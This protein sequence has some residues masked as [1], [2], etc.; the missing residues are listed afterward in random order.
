MG[1][2]RNLVSNLFGVAVVVAASMAIVWPIW[3]VATTWTSWYTLA[4]IMG[5]ALA[6][7]Y[8]IVQKAR[9]RAR[10]ESRIAPRRRG[11]PRP[12]STGVED[13]RQP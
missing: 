9:R 7:T 1:S 3:F 5:M 8:G 2:I 11:K 13:N 12:G 4:V 10:G 6:I